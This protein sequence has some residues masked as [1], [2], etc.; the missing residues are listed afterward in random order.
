MSTYT[1][2]VFLIAALITTAACGAQ[3]VIANAEKIL[4][5]EHY[6]ENNNNSDTDD[7]GEEEDKQLIHNRALEWAKK[8]NHKAIADALED[9]QKV[10]TKDSLKRTP[11]IHAVLEGNLDTVKALVEKKADINAEDDLKRTPLILAAYHGHSEVVTL[12]VNKKANT[13]AKDSEEKT[14]LEWAQSQLDETGDA[15]L[16]KKYNFGR[17]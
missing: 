10:E 5:E 7:K 3:N 14:A 9:S 17:S 8:N 1:Q 2:K 13:A 11:L 16:K 12:L 15:K 4:R 6:T